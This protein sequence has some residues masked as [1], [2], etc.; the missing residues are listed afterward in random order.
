MLWRMPQATHTLSNTVAL[1]AESCTHLPFGGVSRHVLTN[2]R[3]QGASHP[4]P[5][6]SVSPA[7]TTRPTTVTDDDLGQS[8]QLVQVPVLPQQILLLR[9]SRGS[10]WCLYFAP[11]RPTASRGASRM[12]RCKV[13]FA[14]RLVSRNGSPCLQGRKQG[15]SDG[16]T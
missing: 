2:Q 15:C 13:P 3:S 4:A 8:R 12:F 16:C 5:A 1:L 7:L 11:D 14:T 10:Y 9:Q 6:L